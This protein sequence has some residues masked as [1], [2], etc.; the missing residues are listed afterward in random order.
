[1]D[2]M[3]HFFS[4]TSHIFIK[5]IKNWGEIL[6]GVEA[7][8]K[9]VMTDA[10][11]NKLG[12]VIEKSSGIISFF[13]RLIFR[14]HRP[15]DVRVYDSNEVEV[16]RFERP[17]Y[18]FFST[19]KVYSQNN[20]LGQIDQRFAIFKKRYSIVDANES[21]VGIIESG[22]FNFFNFEIEGALG[23][24]IGRISKKW[25][26]LIKE[27]FTDGDTFGVEM[28]EDLAN[29]HKALILSTA[30]SIDFDY[31]EDNQGGRSPLQIF[32]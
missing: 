16:L 23:A 12:W 17:F 28:N 22:F 31:F 20:Y 3:Q 13:S 29:A 14:S 15:L 1:M 18:F 11:G 4:G 2:L 26:G 10:S 7:K 5:Q 24:N 19:A 30:I 9:Y 25:G 32:D 27:I 21:S 6:I 8:N